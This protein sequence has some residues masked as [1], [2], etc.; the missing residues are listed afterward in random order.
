MSEGV[1]RYR[2][3]PRRSASPIILDARAV[4]QGSSA[5]PEFDRKDTPHSWHCRFMAALLY[6][7]KRIPARPRGILSMSAGN[8]AIPVEPRF[9]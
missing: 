7:G 2:N 1:A 5:N 8:T 6:I 4:L 3:D 9:C